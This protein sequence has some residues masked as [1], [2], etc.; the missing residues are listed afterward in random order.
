[1]NP[2]C[3]YRPTRLS[4]SEQWTTAPKNYIL[5]C[6]S[7]NEAD[8]LIGWLQLF[9][10]VDGGRSWHFRPLSSY[11][12]LFWVGFWGWEHTQIRIYSWMI[13]DLARYTMYI[14]QPWYNYNKFLGISDYQKWLWRCC[15][16]R[17][18]SRSIPTTTIDTT[19]F[20][21]MYFE[22]SSSL[23]LS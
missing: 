4:S 12:H 5:V 19:F 11:K 9:V 15:W 10:G 17:W 21:T 13:Y 6:A 22:G 7:I 2:P 20:S 18:C 16:Y 1:M 23:L 8:H 14:T 3:S